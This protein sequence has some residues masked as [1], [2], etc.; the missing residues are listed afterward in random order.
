ML[1]AVECI[2]RKNHTQDVQT[3]V[4][5]GVSVERVRTKGEGR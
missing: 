3:R 5:F 1:E 4:A 2:A